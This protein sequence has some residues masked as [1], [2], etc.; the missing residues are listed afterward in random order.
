M[1]QLESNLC[2]YLHVTMAQGNKA[3]RSGV[4]IICIINLNFEEHLHK[5]EILLTCQPKTDRCM[6]AQGPQMK[7]PLL[8]VNPFGE[9]DVK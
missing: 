1:H 3:Y 5:K 7:F 9:K 2:Q 8:I 6:A 4:H